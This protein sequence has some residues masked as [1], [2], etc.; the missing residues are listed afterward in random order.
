MMFKDF[1]EQDMTDDSVFDQNELI[2]YLIEVNEK[3]SGPGNKLLQTAKMSEYCLTELNRL[4][5]GY[6]ELQIKEKR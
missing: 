2:N 6:L 4:F 1:Y 3:I 5:N